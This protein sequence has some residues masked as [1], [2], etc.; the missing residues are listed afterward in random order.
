ML[1]LVEEGVSAAGIEI[2]HCRVA[3]VVRRI[4]VHA[5]PRTGLE[6]KFSMEYCLAAAALDGEVTLRQFGDDMVQRPGIQRLM[7]RIR[8]DAHPGVKGD[9]KDLL[10]ELTVTLAD[11]QRLSRL[12]SAPR[13]DASRPLTPK[14]LRDKYEQCA[15]VPS[16]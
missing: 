10:S 14:E 1:E 15:A 11:G 6:G 3:D 2:I 13:G 9:K 4:L 5:R 12:G 8:V 16:I 7:S